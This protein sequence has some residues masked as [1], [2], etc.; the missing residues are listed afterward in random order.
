MSAVSTGRRASRGSIIATAAFVGLSAMALLAPSVGAATVNPPGA[1]GTVKIDGLAFDSAPNN[2]PH[3]G[4][5]FQVD[6]YGFDQGAYNANVEFSVK[7]PTGKSTALLTDTVFIGE[8]P[9]GGATDLD[10]ERTYNLSQA[11]LPYTPHPKQGYHV[12]V[13]V[14]AQG[15]DGKVAIKQK[16]FWVQA[17]GVTPPCEIDPTTNECVITTTLAT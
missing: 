13:T 11:L 8:D 5:S 10:A 6:F 9:A 7:P 4:C 16:V 1:N 3:V 2:E 14:S 17:C 12:Y 15:A